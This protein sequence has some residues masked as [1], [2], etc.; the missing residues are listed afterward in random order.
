MSCFS[1]FHFTGWWEGGIGHVPCMCKVLCFPKE[2]CLVV[3][4][5]LTLLSG[6]GPTLSLSPSKNG[7]FHRSLKLLNGLQ[8]VSWC[9]WAS[10]IVAGILWSLL[11]LVVLSPGASSV[12]NRVSHWK[13]SS[14][15]AVGQAGKWLSSLTYR[16]ELNLG[17]RGSARWWDKG[18]SGIRIDSFFVLLCFCCHSFL[19]SFPK[20]S[21]TVLNSLKTNSSGHVLQRCCNHCI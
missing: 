21:S 12:G 19:F 5:S 15:V 20:S 16:Q 14:W 13:F 3:R 10:S 17:T 6:A 11:F 9:L 1:S 18:V 8:R 4:G 2:S 7:V